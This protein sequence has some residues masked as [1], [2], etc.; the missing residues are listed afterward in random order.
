MN[1][2]RTPKKDRAT[3]VC[4]DAY[5]DVWMV[6]RPGEN[7][8]TEADIANMHRADDDE[9]NS[10]YKQHRKG[11]KGVPEAPLSYEEVDED[12]V[13]IGDNT[14]NPL[15]LILAEES[16]SEAKRRVSEAI[17]KLPTK[18]TNAVQAVWL[19]EKSAREYAAEQNCSEANVSALLD[20]AFKNLRKIL[21]R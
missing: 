19:D 15:E 7:G 17:G 9:W 14:A 10:D 8:V 20:R 5:G 4:R 3:Y 18:Q 2:Y 11:R 21:A 16:K 13:W 6:L 12:E 1:K